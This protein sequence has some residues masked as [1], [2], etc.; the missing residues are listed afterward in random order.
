MWGNIYIMG[1][2]WGSNQTSCRGTN[3][4]ISRVNL[5]ER[6]L[7]FY[8]Y[9]LH[10]LPQLLLLLM[11]MLMMSECTHVP[12]TFN[13]SFSAKLGCF[14]RCELCPLSRSK[15]S[16][17]H[18]CIQSRICH[19]GV[20]ASWQTSEQNVWPRNFLSFKWGY[21]GFSSCSAVSQL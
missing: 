12:W 4:P 7:H 11:L 2:E 21:C 13:V 16:Q 5:Y 15:G 17:Q 8:V 10:F 3:W 20:H 1:E 6:V 19:S 14:E 18:W 9:I